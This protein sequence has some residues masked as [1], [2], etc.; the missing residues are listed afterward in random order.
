MPNKIIMLL[1]HRFHFSKGKWK[2]QITLSFCVRCWY[3]HV[4]YFADL[5]ITTEDIG[6]LMEE[7]VQTEI[8]A[9]APC[10]EMVQTQTVVQMPHQVT[11][12]T[13]PDDIVQTAYQEMPIIETF[14]QVPSQQEQQAQRVEKGKRPKRTPK[15]NPKYEQSAVDPK[16]AQKVSKVVHVEKYHPKVK[17]DIDK[18]TKDAQESSEFQEILQEAEMITASLNDI[19]KENNAEHVNENQ[20]DNAASHNKVKTEQYSDDI[21]D[22]DSQ[23]NGNTAENTGK[24]DLVPSSSKFELEEA[25]VGTSAS[26]TSSSKK[27]KLTGKIAANQ[28]ETKVSIEL[29]TSSA[30]NSRCAYSIARVCCPSFVVPCPH[31]QT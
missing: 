18:Q 6:P 4:F 7:T 3:M 26:G 30:F 28:G 25:S 29:M 20:N 1:Q 22:F 14:S 11:A 19:E 9:Q 23:V 16:S 15:R 13:Q 8:I 12:Q 17:V 2:L 27:R 10:Q 24:L 31:F 21:A 5:R